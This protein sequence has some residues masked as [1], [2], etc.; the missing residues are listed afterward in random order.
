[1]TVSYKLCSLNIWLL[2]EIKK[3][4]LEVRQGLIPAAYNAMF[5]SEMVNSSRILKSIYSPYLSCHFAITENI[6]NP[7]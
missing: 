4:F 7:E 1:M 3:A 5:L 2:L 6:Q